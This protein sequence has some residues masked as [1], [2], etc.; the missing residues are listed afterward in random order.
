MF[1]VF[2]AQICLKVAK[3]FEQVS[4]VCEEYNNFKNF[5]QIFPIMF[6][7]QLN[8]WFNTHYLFITK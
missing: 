1:K 7:R 4:Y 5:I 2:G 8:C 3:Q 6:L